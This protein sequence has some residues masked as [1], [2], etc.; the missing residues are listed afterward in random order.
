MLEQIPVPN[1]GIVLFFSANVLAYLIVDKLIIDVGEI[2][3][4]GIAT[5]FL[6]CALDIYRQSKSSA[7]EDQSPGAATELESWPRADAKSL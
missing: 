2:F 4:F 3:E 5:T 7:R 6:L 1:Q